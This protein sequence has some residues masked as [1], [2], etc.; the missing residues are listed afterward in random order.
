V[1]LA[2]RQ[3]AVASS[4]LRWNLQ[5]A[6]VAV[7][8]VLACDWLVHLG[9]RWVV[10]NMIATALFTGINFVAANVWAFDARQ[11]LRLSL[12]GCLAAAA[13][14]ALPVAVITVPQ[15]CPLVYA[16]WLLPLAELTLLA[17]GQLYYRLAFRSGLNTS[18]CR[19][20]PRRIRLWILE[21]VQ[22]DAEA[23]VLGDPKC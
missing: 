18:A 7:P 5:R 20:K 14:L 17:A 15:L 1:D 4:L 21:S 8:N 16:A 2:D 23:G 11:R 6:L 12:P 3:P 13:L 22:G 9:L 10:A 19:A